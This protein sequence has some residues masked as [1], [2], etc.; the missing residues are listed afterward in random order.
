MKH[1]RNTTRL[2]LALTGMGLIMLDACALQRPPQPLPQARPHAR[3]GPEDPRAGRPN[4]R[5][6]D[7][8]QDPYYS[9]GRYEHNTY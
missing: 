8:V 6:R 7:A 3:G 5:A 2:M 1:A 9:S 4:P